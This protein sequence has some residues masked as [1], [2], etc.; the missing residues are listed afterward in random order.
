MDERITRGELNDHDARTFSALSNAVRLTARELGMQAAASEKTPDLSEIVGEYK[1]GKAVVMSGRDV[2]ILDAMRDQR[3]FGF[4]FR[5]LST[6]SAWFA[7]LAGL[8]A[9]PMSESEAQGWREC[10]GRTV[11]L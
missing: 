6:W 3:L 11:L 9:L 5:N 7:F 1:R 4:A 10:T 2:T 8:F